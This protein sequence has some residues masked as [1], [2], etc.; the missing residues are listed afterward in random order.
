MQG[1]TTLFS[2]IHGLYGYDNINSKIIKFFGGNALSYTWQSGETSKPVLDLLKEFYSVHIFYK[3]QVTVNLYIDNIM[4]NTVEFN[5]DTK[6]GDTFLVNQDQCIGYAG[7]IELI[8]T[9]EVYTARIM[10]K[11]VEDSR[12]AVS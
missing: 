1:V 2:D 6:I 8:G 3:G 9:A 4:V 12:F 11:E 10:Y 7:H 5:S